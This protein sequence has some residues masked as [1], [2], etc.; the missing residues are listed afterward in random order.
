[1]DREVLAR[2]PSTA[3]S[4]AISEAQAAQ[5]QTQQ[6]PVRTFFLL[7]FPNSTLPGTKKNSVLPKRPPPLFGMPAKG[8]CNGSGCGNGQPSCRGIA[9]R[10]IF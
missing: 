8:L 3:V 6:I 2:Q 5:E 4:V 1:M 9:L 10:H 7:C